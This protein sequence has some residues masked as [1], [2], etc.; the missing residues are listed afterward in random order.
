[1]SDK[2]IVAAALA[3]QGFPQSLDL[4]QAGS[5]NPMLATQ[6]YPF[7]SRKGRAALLVLDALGA[8]G[9]ALHEIPAYG[10]PRLSSPAVGRSGVVHV[11]LPDPP[12][13]DAEAI[14]D[15]VP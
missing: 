2:L 3:D 8:M 7:L 11:V 13:C 14:G 15:A 12:G 5:A 6:H 1:M 9:T 10:P 4:S